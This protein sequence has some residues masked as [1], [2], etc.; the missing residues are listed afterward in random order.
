MVQGH[1]Q[2]ARWRAVAGLQRER[3]GTHHAARARAFPVAGRGTKA[4]SQTNPCVP[5]AVGRGGE[6]L[7]G[8]AEQ[9]CVMKRHS[10]AKPSGA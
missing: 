6:C 1:A 2:G 3:R 5:C 4:D 9:A 8:E 7:S 10:L